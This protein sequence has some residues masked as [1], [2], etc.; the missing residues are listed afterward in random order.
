MQARAFD[1]FMGFQLVS[2]G[3]VIGSPCLRFGLLDEGSYGWKHGFG[4]FVGY[5][6]YFVD[7]YPCFIL[8][9]L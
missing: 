2:L 1:N 7:Y 4:L 9:P 8:K 3:L 6:I 5:D